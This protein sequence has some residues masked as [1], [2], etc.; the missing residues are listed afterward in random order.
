MTETQTMGFKN[1]YVL[2]MVDQTVDFH[3]IVG[4]YEAMGLAEAA[5]SVLEDRMTDDDLD[6]GLFYRIT[7]FEIGKNYQ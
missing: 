7:S 5:R 4:V 2:E 3:R 1:V 6:I